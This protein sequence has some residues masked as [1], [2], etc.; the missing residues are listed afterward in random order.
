MLGLP[1]LLA[2]DCCLVPSGGS[3]DCGLLASLLFRLLA[4]GASLDGLALRLLL[5]GEAESVLKNPEM[6][7][8]YF[9]GSVAK[10]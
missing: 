5:T 9:G 6:S 1:T 4:L 2:V 3:I 7:A 10:A 8:L